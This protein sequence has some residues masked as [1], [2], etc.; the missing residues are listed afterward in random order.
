MNDNNNNDNND[1]RSDGGE[2]WW[3]LPLLGFLAVVGT[4]VQSSNTDAP[5]YVDSDGE[6]S[7]G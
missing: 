3:V 7:C 1:N 5:C 6:V 4:M 2:Y